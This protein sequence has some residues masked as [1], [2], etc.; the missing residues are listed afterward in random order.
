MSSFD[1]ISA[2]LAADSPSSAP[3][4]VETTTPPISEEV[5]A[6]IEG[7]PG[8]DD[9]VPETEAPAEEE[10]A[11]EAEAQPEPSDDEKPQIE[12]LTESRWKRVHSGYKYTQELGKA[13]GIVGEDGRVDLS[14]FPPIEQ[15][16][17]MQ[18]AYSDRLAMEH[19]FA[20][21]DPANAQ[22]FV[23]NWNN[24]SPKGM[25][26][27]A[28]QMPEYLAQANQEAYVALAQPVMTRFWNHMLRTAAGSPDGELKSALVDA[29]RVSEW[30]A[31]GGVNAPE[32][33]YRSDEEIQK[34]MQQPRQ[35]APN[36]TALKLQQAEAQLQRI[37]Q[38]GAEA[39]W[40]STYEQVDRAVGQEIGAAMEK[41]LAPL[42]AHYPNE[43]TF[44]AVRDKFV[45][46]IQK[47]MGSNPYEKRAFELAQEQAK[48]GQQGGAEAMQKAWTAW[49]R[50]AM[51]QAAPNFIAE[52]SKGIKAASDARH[53]A[54]AKGAAKKGPVSGGA[55][56]AQSIVPGI[57]RAP[58][59]SAADYR[60]RQITADMSA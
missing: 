2:D 56:R 19:D 50:K 53:T 54:L 17:G 47:A 40:K 22:Q 39:R 10:A 49:T 14:L 20:S 42:K 12:N 51:A 6:E 7:I 31:A 27:M 30:L 60:L 37:Q 55:A 15:V 18:Q 33:S 1:Q 26:T 25:A 23:E 36:Q 52:A 4:A 34:L 8:D 16:Q 59:E 43:M 41:T 21:A 48:R 58:G 35:Q 32:G 5:T 46:Q 9:A 11:P 3:E 29:A 13:L 57:Q 38:Q 45:A 28:A 44:S 24:F